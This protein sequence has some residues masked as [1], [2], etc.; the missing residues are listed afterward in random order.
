[1]QHPIRF[2]PF[3]RPMVW[4]G[5]NLA[6]L[7]AKPLPTADDYG[8]AWEVS[9]HASH[10]SVIAD[11][12]DAGRTLRDL[13]ARD[14]HRLL[15]DP[16]HTAFPWLIKY[17]DAH[18]WLSV[19]VHPDEEAVRRLWPGEGSKTEAWFVLAARPDSRVYAG[20]Q[21]GVDEAALR[22]AIAA[23]TVADLLHAFEPR[24][25]DCL[26][27]PAGTV[28]AVGGGVLIAEVQQTS[29]ATFRLFDWNRRDASGKSR[30][31]HI[32]EAIAC[33]DWTAG[34]VHP[35][36][37]SGYPQATDEPPAAEP[38]GQELVRCRYFHLDYIRQTTPFPVAGQGRLQTMLVLHGTGRYRSDAGPGILRPGDTVLLP[39]ALPPLTVEPDGPLGLLL[40]T[41]PPSPAARR[42]A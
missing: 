13:L 16:D 38:V 31:L 40:S 8:E 28:H 32:E 21:P 17:L 34:P 35:V 19:Q 30:T 10:R 18:D 11:G 14:P 20:L 29:D 41:L 1:M 2:R 24:P 42:C 36:R 33:I 26:F 6:A 5:R 27:L 39:A 7:L 9:D 12:P 23:G 37:A 3:L 4:G 25:G 22:R 15:G